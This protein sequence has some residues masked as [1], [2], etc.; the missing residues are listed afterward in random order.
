MS[1][2]TFETATHLGTA[3]ATLL[4]RRYL[5]DPGARYD[6]ASGLAT[7]KVP[8]EM[9]RRELGRQLEG[10]ADRIV[11]RLRSFITTATR[12]PSDV[13]A[14]AV[15]R[16]LRAVL[17]VPFGIELLAGREAE[18]AGLTRHLQQESSS[19]AVK[20]S[21]AQA[22]LHGIA[23]ER[24]V[25]FLFQATTVLPRF[26]ALQVPEVLTRLAHSGLD[27]ELVLRAVETVEDRVES[28]T[29]D[30]RVEADYRIAL[31]EEVDR[32]DLFGADIPPEAQRNLLTEAFVQLNVTGR[33][34]GGEEEHRLLSFESLL[35][36]MS[37]DGGR[38]LIRGAAGSGK[39]TLLRWAA[40]QAAGLERTREGSGWTL[41]RFD[42]VTKGE[43]VPEPSW[44]TRVPI[45][46]F[47]RHV[48]EERMPRPEDFPAL[49]A[50]GPGRPPETWIRSI[51]ASGQALVLLDGVDEV[52]R[53]VR[54]ELAE[55]L[56]S[57]LGAFP[58]NSWVVTT[59]P[60][61]VTVD[62]LDDMAFQK[63]R[64][65]PLSVQDRARFVRQWHKAVEGEL[66]R[67]GR[68]ADLSPEAEALIEN[69]AENPALGPLATNPLLCAMICALHRERHRKLPEDEKD[70]VEALCHML[71]HRRERESGLDASRFPES[72]RELNY[73]QKRA[74]VQEIACNMVETG[75]SAVHTDVAT[76]WIAEALARFPG[77]SAQE[78][79]VV[80]ETLIERSGML[81]ETGLDQVDFLHNT[82]KE[83][84]AGER[85][86]DESRIEVLEEMALAEGSH[87][88]ALFAVAC[89]NLSFASAFVRRLLYAPAKG[90]DE[91][92][93]R[94]VL[95]LQ[96]QAVALALDPDLLSRLEGLVAEL[97]PPRSLEDAE[98]LARLGDAAVPHLA[99]REGMA[100]EEAV[101]SVRALRLIHTGAARKRL[102]EYRD[103]RSWPVAV[104][105]A[106][107]V[108]PLEIPLVRERVLEGNQVPPE[109]VRQV[110]DLSPLAGLEGVTTL[111]LTNTWVSDLAPLAGLSSLQRLD[112]DGTQVSDLAPL[113]GLSGLERLNLA[114]TQVSD[115]APLAGLS[116]LQRLDL[117]GT[118]VSD[119]AP[120]AGLSSLESLDLSGTQVSDLA[121]LAG[122]SSLQGLDLKETQV[123]DLAPLAGLSSLQGL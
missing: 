39:T 44:R 78:A 51:L 77:R 40:L 68:Q 61:A 81:R 98:A 29:G 114:R 69:L 8:D 35:D 87:R 75:V 102:R 115:L 41:R 21:A 80:L 83:Y 7:G 76:A 31:I 121:P 38:L 93:A 25:R 1:Q 122:L 107:A 119:L 74:L 111:D 85:L 88:V 104:E 32:V 71:L 64:V 54:D 86:A 11:R 116:S 84:L 22:R 63:A 15:A 101:A 60:D 79:G 55:G 117:T 103:A 5:T 118:Q 96:C 50:G 6:A 19:R 36:R 72:Y 26:D 12:V 34:D 91:E 46:V 113:A 112:L 23:L 59:R 14:E 24:S 45:L 106:Q 10:I 47:L 30:W 37:G 89:S 49:V 42:E 99:R 105:L 73:R 66:T 70:L 67:R 52:P 9:D 108:N 56:R 100:E 33:E 53:A 57:L 92:R 20:L 120:L 27:V 4:A 16:E 82:F 13:D 123:S 94:K 2:I 43:L 3:L 110:T 48:A 97:F 58:G 109:I 18:P 95:A 90:P 17:E 65:S 28:P 62:W